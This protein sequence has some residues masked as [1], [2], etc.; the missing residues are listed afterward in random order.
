M[1]LEKDLKIDVCVNVD[2]KKVAKNKTK[3]SYNTVDLKTISPNQAVLKAL[4]PY[5]YP[6]DSVINISLISLNIKRAE[7]NALSETTLQPLRA[8]PIRARASLSE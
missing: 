8:R 1:L 3:K 2:S 5:K 6:N 4:K 7:R